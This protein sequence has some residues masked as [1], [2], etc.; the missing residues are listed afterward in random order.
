MALVISLRY[1]YNVTYM[2]ALW[3]SMLRGPPMPRPHQ[4]HLYPTMPHQPHQIELSKEARIQ[5]TLLAI[6]QDATLLLRRI[7]AIY[8]VPQTIL[9]Y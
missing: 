3:P 4:N 5:T 6:K 8:N 7:T 9:R 2:H 1:Y